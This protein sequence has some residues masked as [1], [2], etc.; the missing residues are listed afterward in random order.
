MTMA[1]TDFNEAGFIE[2]IPSLFA[3]AMQKATMC[4]LLWNQ[5]DPNTIVHNMRLYDIVRRLYY[6][7]TNT[8]PTDERVLKLVAIVKGHKALLDF[9]MIYVESGKFPDVDVMNNIHVKYLR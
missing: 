7:K 5:Q 9:F 1:K 2:S 4:S 6:V 8:E 3:T